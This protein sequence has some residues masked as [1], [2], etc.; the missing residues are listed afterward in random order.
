[1]IYQ[2]DLQKMTSNM[3]GCHHGGYA[4]YE[5]MVKA[6]KNGWWWNP[7]LSQS[8]FSLLAFKIS[9]IETVVILWCGNLLNFQCLR[10]SWYNKG[11][12][13]PYCFHCC[14]KGI[15]YGTNKIFTRRYV[16]KDNVS[17]L[18]F[19]CFFFFFFNSRKGLVN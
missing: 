19:W 11:I 8:R 14:S 13:N 6:V 16:R 10:C 5:L 15:C 2:D 7:W 17:I 18:F 3:P 9:N 4:L 1:M 12:L